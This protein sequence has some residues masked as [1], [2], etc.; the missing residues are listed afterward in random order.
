MLIIF[1]V[2]FFVEHHP[3][4]HPHHTLAFQF[5]SAGKGEEGKKGYMAHDPIVTRPSVKRTQEKKQIIMGTR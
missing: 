1:V 3:P 4:L 2:T 5:T